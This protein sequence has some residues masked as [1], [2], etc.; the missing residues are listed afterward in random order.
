MYRNSSILNSNSY[1]R[2]MIADGDTF[3]TRAVTSE[4][5]EGS[6]S[7]HISHQ[8]LDMEKVDRTATAGY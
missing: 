1:R 5:G 6:L 4:K 3:L 7:K 8:D 2:Q